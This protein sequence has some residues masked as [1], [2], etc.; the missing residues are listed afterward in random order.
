M[1]LDQQ[2][3]QLSLAYALAVASTARCAVREY[4]VD[5]DS[6]DITISSTQPGTA[7]HSPMVEVQ[8]KATSLDVLGSQDINFPLKVKNYNDLRQRTLVPRILVVMLLPNDPEGWLKQAE[9]KTQVYRCAYWRSLWGMPATT[10]TASVT[11]AVPRSN[12]FSPEALS[13]IMSTIGNGGR[14]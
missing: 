8:L 12:I 3:E 11:V 13:R 14:P 2:K 6:V 1:T 9:F 7:L 10:N 5:D 4:R